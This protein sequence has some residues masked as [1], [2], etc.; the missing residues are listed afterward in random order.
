MRLEVIRDIVDPWYSFN[1]GEIIEYNPWKYEY[2]G[3]SEKN[4]IA[5]GVYVFCDGHGEFR[6]Y[7]E[8]VEVKKL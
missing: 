7:N 5:K 2:Q 3:E 6:V 4:R 1:K 8:G